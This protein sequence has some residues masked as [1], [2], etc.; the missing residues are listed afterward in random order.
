ML[1]LEGRDTRET[2]IS[3]KK[4]RKK[5]RKKSTTKK[6]SVLKKHTDILRLSPKKGRCES[7]AKRV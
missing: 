5:K 7:N 2:Q 6:Q 4:K 3:K 1:E